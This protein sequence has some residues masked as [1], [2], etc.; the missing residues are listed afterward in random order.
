[1]SEEEIFNKVAGLVDGVTM[2]EAHMND[3]KNSQ[4]HL[5]AVMQATNEMLNIAIDALA[6]IADPTSGC[7]WIARKSALAAMQRVNAIPIPKEEINLTLETPQP[8]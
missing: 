4:K 6:M 3:V 1:M 7:D 8:S 5:I 2:L